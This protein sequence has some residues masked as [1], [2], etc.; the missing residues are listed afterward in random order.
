MN[1]I[2][3][4]RNE[5]MLD[6]VKS[7]MRYILTLVSLLGA[8]ACSAAPKT[9]SAN[10]P[11][12]PL[13]LERVIPLPDVAGRIDHVAIDVT[14]HQLFVAEYGNG[15][16]D[17]IDL[18]AGRVIGRIRGLNEPQG[19]AVLAGGQQ[20]L[21]ACGD[22]AVHFYA[23][24]D[25]HEIARLMLGDDADNVQID[26]R[27]GHVVVGYGG[28]GLAVIDAVTHRVLSRLSLTGHPEGFELLGSR[29][30]ANVPDRGSILVG[31]IDTGR[32]TATWS[33]GTH[34]LN[35]P[36]AVDPAGRWLAL[37]YRFPA[38]LQMRD[39]ASGDVIATHSACGDADDLFV[40]RDRAYLIC[41]T[42]H[43]DV[44]PTPKPEDQWVR[45]TTSPGARTGIFVPELKRLFVAVPARGGNA[46][47]WVL[48]IN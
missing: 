14:H 35:F 1:W 39:A 16:V 23:T 32:L 26:T 4:R 47:I 38:A 2:G 46:A 12:S 15:T 20:V 42:G 9:F 18:D 40:D 37:A 36:M 21:V 17:A 34:R 48:R 45:V 10:D 11:A 13:T 31:D 7:A 27:N 3:T 41:G 8:T 6:I 24:D 29:I 28:G 43:V 22:G 44:F 5:S 30:F 25:R 19:I 33:T